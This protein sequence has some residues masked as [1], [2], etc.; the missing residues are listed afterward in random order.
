METTQSQLKN[1]RTGFFIG[2][3]LVVVIIIILIIALAGGG[4]K[5]KSKSANEMLM[6]GVAAQD[7]EPYAT[8]PFVY[9]FQGIEWIFD[10]ST[11]EG[12]RI[13]LTDIKLWFTNFSRH[14]GTV[15]KFEKPYKLG[16]YL[17]DCQAIEALELDIETEGT[18]LAY[19]QCAYEGE[20]TDIAVFQEDNMI[21]FKKRLVSSGSG[22]GSIYSVDITEM[23]K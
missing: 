21:H 19:A 22:F 13:P 17:G 4:S 16:T 23:V 15:V 6:P 9:Q 5:E 7:M 12:A 3:G 10:L 8:G 18:P 2:L 11:E 20:M 14:N 1:S